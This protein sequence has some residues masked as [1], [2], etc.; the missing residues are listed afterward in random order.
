MGTSGYN[1]PE[2]RGSFYPEKLR[3]SAMLPF[4]SERFAT[5]EINATFYRMPN[6]ATLAAWDAATPATFVFTLKAPQRITHMR[7][8]RDVDELVRVF[9]DTAH[10]LG[11]KLGP[12]LFQLPPNFAKDRDRLADLLVLV[13]PGLRCA[14]EFRH[15]SWFAED[16][17]ELL[18]ARDAALCIADTEEGTTPDVATASWGYLRLRDAEYG[19]GELE[20][21]ARRAAR[22]SWADAYVYFKH[23]MGAPARARK[24][25]ECVVAHRSSW[26]SGPG[27]VI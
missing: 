17:Y 23:A 11:P 20:A 8:L 25:G 15:P 27:F 22:E 10:T 5:V 19:D 18:R 12:L 6:A 26:R 14:L 7:R 2:W 1:Y 13:P 24:F 4:Y 16:V 21:W 9:C 3:A